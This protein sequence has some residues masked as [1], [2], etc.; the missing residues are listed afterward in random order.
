MARELEPPKYLVDRLI[1]ALQQDEFVLYAQN[2]LALAPKSGE[3]P[4]QEVFVRFKEE[5]T[6]LLPPGS[7]FPVLEECKLL[8]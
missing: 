5:D 7:F 4:F 2:I 3:R 8:P 1:A 6:K